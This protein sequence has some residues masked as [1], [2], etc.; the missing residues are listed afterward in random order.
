MSCSP[1]KISIVGRETV[2]GED[3]FILKFLQGRNP[4]WTDR[5][6]FSK[7]SNTATWID[8]LVP[9]FGEEKFFFEDE[10]SEMI[11]GSDRT[12]GLNYP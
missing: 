9:A 3:V 5:V 7:Y 6:F 4:N 1:G 8:Q 11:S 12:I 10:L 2:A